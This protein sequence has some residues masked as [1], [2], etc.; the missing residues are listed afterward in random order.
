MSITVLAPHAQTRSQI[1][2]HSLRVP[3]REQVIIERSTSGALTRRP[4]PVTDTHSIIRVLPQVLLELF[5]GRILHLKL[6]A[7]FLLVCR[8]DLVEGLEKA[9]ASVLSDRR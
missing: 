8:E 1:L 6:D 9:K 4:S 7:V 3:T 5:D 2:H